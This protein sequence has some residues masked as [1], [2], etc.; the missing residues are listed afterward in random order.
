MN[1]RS[2]RWRSH[3]GKLPLLHAMHRT[4]DMDHTEQSKTTDAQ[5]HGRRSDELD[6]TSAAAVFASVVSAIL[7][8]ICWASRLGAASDGIHYVAMPL[9][10]A[11]FLINAPIALR[12]RVRSLRS[13]TSWLATDGAIS[14]LV[15][16]MTVL[17][18]VALPSPL[19]YILPSLGGLLFAIHFCRWC[20]VERLRTVWIWLLGALTVSVVAGSSYWGA[21]YATPLYEHRLR[22][23]ATNLDTTFHAAVCAMTRTYGIPSTGLDGTPY[24]PYHHGSHFMFAA[25]CD[26]LEIPV[27]EF[28]NSAY[29]II[30]IPLL[31]YALLLAG[32]AF[33]KT[34][35]SKRLVSRHC[36]VLFVLLALFGDMLPRSASKA[37][38]LW[39]NGIWISESMCVATTV[40]L[41]VIAAVVPPFLRRLSQNDQPARFESVTL[42]AAF[43]ILLPTLGFLKVSVMA[44]AL[45]A[46]G[47]LYLRLGLLRRSILASISMAA[48]L[49]VFFGVMPF[50][51]GSLSSSDA[52][53][54]FPFHFI[55]A[56]LPRDW[57]GYFLLGQFAWLLVAAYMRFA[58]LRIATL[59]SL[60]HHL[61]SARLLDLEV[62][63]VVG[64][65][66]LFPAMLLKI[67][68]GSAYYFL[69]VQHLV[70]IAIL[71][72][73]LYAGYRLPRYLD[74]RFLRP[75]RL[76]IASIAFGFVLMAMV[77]TLI[78]NSGASML[79]FAR[80]NLVNRG[81]GADTEARMKLKRSL[82]GADFGRAWELFK[83]TTARVEQSGDP[84]NELVAVLRQLRELSVEEKRRTA[85]FIPKANRTFWESLPSPYSKAIPLL[86][87]AVTEIAMIDG[88]PDPDP[89]IQYDGYGY[90]TYTLPRAP[91]ALRTAPQAKSVVLDRAGE[92]GF[93]R[94]LVLDCDTAGRPVI[95]EWHTKNAG[96]APLDIAGLLN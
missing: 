35:R 26:L 3:A 23:G 8:M 24:L 80:R 60:V 52:S 11:L 56:Y 36:W 58:Q 70:A 25:F 50:V 88:L 44:L 14:L 42:A 33:A 31:V 74:M 17:L 16:G 71:L 19:R 48:A 18:G 65:A 15:L 51:M 12:L 86:A 69:C 40:M 45:V 2:Q 34:Y 53:G 73:V 95:T 62:I 93:E 37:V 41:L 21:D 38:G 39:N 78:L 7:A 54:I 79:G 82:Y 96:V 27:I 6:S 1:S 67:G 46:A 55:R 59:S 87:P 75:G 72:G 20:R 47:Y 76:P 63:L 22:M 89:N 28:Y 94:V 84:R 4:E 81:F 10:L 92:L 29:G 68:G 77:T 32:I 57:V 30:C 85:L 13:S 66:G 83:D 91:S 9:G 5:A 61:K 64:V 90:G 43:P 49:I